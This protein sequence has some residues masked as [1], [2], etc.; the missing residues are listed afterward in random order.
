[1]L[2]GLGTK[3]DEMC[4]HLM[5]HLDKVRLFSCQIDWNYTADG[6]FFHVHFFVFLPE[7][8]FLFPFGGTMFT[9]GLRTGQTYF[10]RPAFFKL[11][12]RSPSLMEAASCRFRVSCVHHYVWHVV[13]NRPIATAHQWKHP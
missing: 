11:A 9:F 7:L 4:R 12:S 5:T 13:G 1:M 2:S 10:F 6:S 3:T 8:R